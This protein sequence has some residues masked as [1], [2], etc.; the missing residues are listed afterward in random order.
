[1]KKA[2]KEKESLRVVSY[3]VHFGKNTKEIAKVFTHDGNLS[4]ADIILFQEIEFHQA[5][6]IARAEVIAK[7]LGFNFA[8]EP[9]RKL[10]GEATHGLAT[11]SR[12]PIKNAKTIRLPKNKIFFKTQQRIAL[13]TKISV[14]GKQIII[15]NIHLDTRL[16]PNKRIIQLNACLKRLK[17]LGHN[18]IIAGDFNTIPFRSVG[19]LFPVLYSNQSKHLHNHMLK[20]GFKYFCEPFSYTMKRGPL[21]MRLDHIYSSNLPIL[22]C[23]VEEKIKVSDHKP[24]WADLSLG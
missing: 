15:C 5:E 7:H 4:K 24:I 22:G 14:K 16:N 1:M 8:Y 3:N 11:L 20:N 9:A 6:K 12:W 17:P 23:G 2:V 10:K 21:R 19:G 13:I 18:I